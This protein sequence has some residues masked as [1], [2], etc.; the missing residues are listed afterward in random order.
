M[1]R[2]WCFKPVSLCLKIKWSCVKKKG[3]SFQIVMI[4]TKNWRNKHTIYLLGM[5]QKH[6]EYGQGGLWGRV[7]AT[8]KLRCES[9]TMLVRGSSHS[10]QAQGQC[11]VVL[12]RSCWVPVWRPKEWWRTGWLAWGISSS[13]L[14]GA[15]PLL[16]VHPIPPVAHICW[17]VIMATGEAQEKACY[18]QKSEQ[19]GL[20]FKTDE[21]CVSS[22]SLRSWLFFF[23]VLGHLF[24][25]CLG[26]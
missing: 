17:W 11:P 12:C 9:M 25:S 8:E 10:V 13:G 26:A 7:T 19:F 6:L 3:T 18:Q 1:K 20:W 22:V 24:V 14:E 4:A 2:T 15:H 5:E 16:W 21:N 23:S